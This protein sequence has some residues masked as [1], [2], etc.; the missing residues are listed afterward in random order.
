MKQEFNRAM[1]QVTL[2][3]RP[4]QDHKGAGGKIRRIAP[5]PPRTE[6]EKLP[7]RLQPPRS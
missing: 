1:D 3:Q 5:P 7:L 4:R 6:V 2:P